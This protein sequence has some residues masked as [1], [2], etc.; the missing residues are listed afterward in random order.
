MSFADNNITVFPVLA[1]GGEEPPA[2]GGIDPIDRRGS[3]SFPG[4]L[5]KKLLMSLFHFH[6]LITSCCCSLH[7]SS[8]GRNEPIRSRPPEPGLDTFSTIKRRRSEP[9]GKG[10]RRQRAR[11]GAHLSPPRRHTQTLLFLFFFLKG[12]PS[13]RLSN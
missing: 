6:Q 9:K 10:G 12:Q 4:D 8:S 5:L 13:T 2:L 1:V 3:M 7:L 11:L